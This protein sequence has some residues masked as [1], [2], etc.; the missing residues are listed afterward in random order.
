MKI[1]SAMMVNLT[2]GEQA[3]IWSD[4]TN[5]IQAFDMHMRGAACFFRINKRDNKQAQ[6]FLKEAISIDEKYAMSYAILG[7]THFLDFLYGWSESPIESFEKA[8]KNV[9]K[10]FSLNESLDTPHSLMSWIYLFKRRHE[11][12][13]KEGDRAIEL[14]PNGAEAHACLVLVL[15]Y[16]DETELAIKLSKKALRLNPI[17]PPHYYF[18]LAAAYRIGGQYEK[19]IQNLKKA[20]IGNPDL[21]TPHLYLTACYSSLNRTEEARKAAEEVLRIEPHFSLEYHRNILPYK[22]QETLN[23]YI[24]ALRK[25]GLPE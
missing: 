13:I 6:Y 21:L 10:S 5:N 9:V 15:N 19:A 3:R 2:T 1:V 18:W 7:F 23:N 11:E 22:N 12:A 17:P 14:N 8:E 16:S 25:A 24:D 20:L 4:S